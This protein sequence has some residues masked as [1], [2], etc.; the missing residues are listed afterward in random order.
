MHCKELDI[1][2]LCYFYGWLLISNSDMI[3]IIPKG[4]VCIGNI[5]INELS[6]ASYILYLS[7]IFCGSFSRPAFKLAHKVILG[8]ISAF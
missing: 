6:A 1:E 5:Q 4:T 2:W 3:L 8:G 7:A